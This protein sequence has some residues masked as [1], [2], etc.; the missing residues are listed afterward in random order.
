MEFTGEY[1]TLIVRHN[2]QPGVICRVT[3]VLA[4]AAI[5]VAGMKVFRHSRGQDAYMII[6]TDTHVAPHVQEAVFA[7]SDN[8]LA[9]RAIDNQ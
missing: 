6:E 1:P 8:I 4:D 5:N 7:C 9:I 2:D 3:A